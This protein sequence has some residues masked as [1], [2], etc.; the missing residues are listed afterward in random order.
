MSYRK[1]SA[2][3]TTKGTKNIFDEFN[4][5]IENKNNYIYL[6]FENIDNYENIIINLLKL[7]KKQ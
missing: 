4:C 1:F 6:C 7:L 3:N 5:K 2:S